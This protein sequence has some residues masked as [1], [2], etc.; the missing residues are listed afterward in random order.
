VWRE[1]GPEGRLVVEVMDDGAGAAA[2]VANGGLSGLADRLAALDGQLLVQSPPG[3]PTLV[4]AEIPLGDGGEEAP[5]K[6]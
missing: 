2:P 5:R 4:R 6:P 3:G 1:A